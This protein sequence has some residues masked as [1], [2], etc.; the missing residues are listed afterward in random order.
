MKE[1][2]LNCVSMSG[3]NRAGGPQMTWCPQAQEESC[4]AGLW[5]IMGEGTPRSPKMRPEEVRQVQASS[6]LTL[7]HHMATRGDWA[8]SSTISTEDS[9]VTGQP[10]SW[11]DTLGDKV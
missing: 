3:D 11:G 9:V 5:E 8:L 7:P 4:L 1:E 10:Q 6:G 2:E